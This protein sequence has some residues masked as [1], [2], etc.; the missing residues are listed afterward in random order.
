MNIKNR[1]KYYT[2]PIYFSLL[3]N[4]SFNLHAKNDDYYFDLEAIEYDKKSPINLTH[5]LKDENQLPGVYRVDV[6]LNNK[7]VAT[8]DITFIN[9]E[10][11]K[12]YPV[13][14]SSIL[15]S[16]G[17]DANF[18]KQKI[19]D[20]LANDTMID[21]WQQNKLAISAEFDFHQQSLYLTFP[22]IAVIKNQ[23]VSSLQSGVPVFFVNYRYQGANTWIK[24]VLISKI[25]L[26]ACSSALTGKPGNCAIMVATLL[27]IDGKIIAPRFPVIFMQSI[28]N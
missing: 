12:L 7:N 9:D 25:I 18:I 13:V 24:K 2:S 26:L 22:Q 20:Q 4:I 27:I 15:N 6:F 10:Q 14:N 21:F 8:Q 3:F 23:Q 16:W 19:I 11:G 1:I 5:F 17:I 28:A